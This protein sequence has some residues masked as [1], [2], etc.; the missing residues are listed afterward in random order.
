MSLGDPVS[1]YLPREPP[2]VIMGFDREGKPVTRPASTEMKVWNLVTH[3]S[4]YTY[5]LWDE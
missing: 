1:K 2:E 3:T 4:G 5:D